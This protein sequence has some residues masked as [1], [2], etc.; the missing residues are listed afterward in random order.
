MLPRHE[1]LIRLAQGAPR[2]LVDVGAD[3][4]YVARALDGIA[5]ERFEHR[6]QG[7]GAW[8]VSDGLTAYGPLGTAIVAGMGARRILSILD[9]GPPIQRVVLHAQDDPPRLR[10]GLAERGWRIVDEGLAPEAR[11][12]A[13][14]VV[15]E[16][17]D[18]TATG[19]VLDYGPHLIH[20]SDP[21]REAHF[22]QLHGWLSDMVERTHGT[23]VYTDFCARLR[24]VAGI[25]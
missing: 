19:L 18:E 1:V 23:P 9:D 12:Y 10:R 16:P 8:V 13:E 3:H 15:A 7:P 20:G 24:F 6:I 14:V 22:R 25:L 2:P 4:G 5:S 11:R 21:Y 17:G